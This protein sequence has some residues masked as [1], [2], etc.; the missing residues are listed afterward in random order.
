MMMSSNPEDRISTDQ[1][2][3][4]AIINPIDSQSDIE[5]LSN[6]LIEQF[7]SLS[8]LIGTPTETIRLAGNIPDCIIE[9]ID[10][11]RR[12]INYILQQETRLGDSISTIESLKQYMR[13]KLRH[14]ER[15]HFVVFYL[16]GANNI[17]HEEVASIGT[18]NKVSVYPREILRTALKFN[19][20]ALIFVHNHPSGRARPSKEDISFTQD[21]VD[22]C[23]HLN[24][25][26]HDHIIIGSDGEI[27]L[28]QEGLL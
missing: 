18:V 7:G 8:R 16:N 27:S 2:L 11:I 14:M 4:K 28:R 22:A 9:R 5:Q 23:E 26:L 6:A 19:A 1:E 21:M 24:I 17:I 15:E 10:N 20:T 3:L 25:I 12:T 13:F